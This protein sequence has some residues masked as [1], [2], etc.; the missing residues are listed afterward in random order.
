MNSAMILLYM[1]DFENRAILTSCEKVNL[2]QLSFNMFFLFL[3]VQ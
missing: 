3:M 1:L 2:H